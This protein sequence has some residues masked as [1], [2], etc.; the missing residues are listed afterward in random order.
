MKRGRKGG[1]TAGRP[2]AL[3]YIENDGTIHL[4]RCSRS[5]CS[6]RSPNPLG[7]TPLLIQLNGEINLRLANSGNDKQEHEAATAAEYKTRQ[8]SRCISPART[9]RPQ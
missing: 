8:R 6:R 1:R 2:C 5:E 3:V 9:E 7:W 4:G